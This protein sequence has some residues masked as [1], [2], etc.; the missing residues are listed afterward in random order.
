MFD[1][2]S[3]LHGLGFVTGAAIV[4][5]WLSIR[6]AARRRQPGSEVTPDERP[7]ALPATGRA[8]ESDK[9]AEAASL[10]EDLRMVITGKHS[11]I[12]RSLQDLEVASKSGQEGDNC[13]PA[14][15]EMEDLKADAHTLEQSESMRKN[16]DGLAAYVAPVL[17]S[18]R[19][20]Y[21]TQR[22][23]PHFQ[24]RGSGPYNEP[25]ED[26]RSRPTDVF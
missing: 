2:P 13:F 8:C 12:L 20:D 17:C 26:L 5:I 25:A 15:M 19:N 16:W 6:Q 9:S 14:H 7:N 11:A 3:A 1:M 18:A 21:I 22:I 24:G 4:S 23:P 10:L